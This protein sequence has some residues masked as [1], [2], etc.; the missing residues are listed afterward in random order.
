M[1]RA[2]GVSKVTEMNKYVMHNMVEYIKT[3]A[4]FPFDAIDV[5]E[6]LEEV[7]GYYGFDP[8]LDAGER[9]LLRKDLLQVALSAELAEMQH[10]AEAESMSA[11]EDVG[12]P[13]GLWLKVMSRQQRSVTPAQFVE[14]MR[15]V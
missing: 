12:Q 7:L 10:L 4:E 1:P 14:R 13:L 5:E 8:Q 15:L 9:E 11:L 6:S 2:D 3:Q